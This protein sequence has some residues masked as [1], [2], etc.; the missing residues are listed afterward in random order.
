MNQTII[1]KYMW[2]FYIYIYI[3]GFKHLPIILNGFPRNKWGLLH[4]FC[5]RDVM[6]KALDS[7]SSEPSLYLCGTCS[8]R[9]RTGQSSSSTQTKKHNINDF[10]MH[11]SARPG[12]VPLFHYICL[13]IPHV[14]HHLVAFLCVLKTISLFK[15]AT[16]DLY[17]YPQKHILV[18]S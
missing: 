3:F 6:V 17:S 11:A 15:C 10:L 9:R 4:M 13:G 12:H 7:E 2:K 18:Y 16:I 8:L 1:D 5:S 14:F